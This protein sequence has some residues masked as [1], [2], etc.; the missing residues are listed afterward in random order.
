MDREKVIKGLESCLKIP[1]FCNECP[2]GKYNY[3]DQQAYPV[4]GCVEKL[5]NDTLALLKEQETVI[6]LYH[7]ADTFLATHGWSWEG[8]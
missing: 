1:G 8:R 3:D 7:K 2:Y 4:R 5:R 6:E